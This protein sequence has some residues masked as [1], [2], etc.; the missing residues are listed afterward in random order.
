MCV[1]QKPS[2][3]SSDGRFECGQTGGVVSPLQPR[4]TDRYYPDF[5]IK[6]G[7][8]ASTDRKPPAFLIGDFKRQVTTIKPNKPQW[9]AIMSHARAVWQV[10]PI[11]SGTRSN[12]Q[13][14]Q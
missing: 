2:G 5:V 6:Q 4:P 12:Q 11:G 13:G 9:D 3:L 1:T 10:G 7:G 8:P 14:H